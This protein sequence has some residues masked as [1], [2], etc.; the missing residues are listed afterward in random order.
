MTDIADTERLVKTPR[1]LLE[2]LVP[3][4]APMLFDGL[5]DERLYQYHAGRPE[6][7]ESLA[8]RFTQL[9]ARRSPDGCET[10]LNWAIRRNDGVYVGWVQASIAGDQAIIGYDIFA[11]HWRN[12]YA[13]EACAAVLACLKHNFGSRVVRAVVDIENTASIRLLESLGFTRV[14]T[15]PSE[16]LQGRT[17]HKFERSLR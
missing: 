8:L 1:L 9:A 6:T 2:P 14:W 3:A 4:H 16:D 7:L 11:E 5:R 17:D 10:W 15:G 12:G 13:K